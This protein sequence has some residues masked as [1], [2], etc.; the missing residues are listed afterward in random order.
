VK[1]TKTFEIQFDE[2]SPHWLCADN[3]ALV[4][5]QVCKN[6][7]FRVKELSC[8]PPWT[9]CISCKQEALDQ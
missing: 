6:T 9:A 2:P 8:E 3:L 5:H 7:K 4:L 1:V